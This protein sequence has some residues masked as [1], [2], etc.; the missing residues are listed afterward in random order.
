MENSSVETVTNVPMPKNI[1]FEVTTLSKTLAGALF[2]V[3]PFVGAY[4]GAQYRSVLPADAITTPQ[5][6][7]ATTLKDTMFDALTKTATGPLDL[8]LEQTGVVSGQSSEGYNFPVKEV[9]TEPFP[10]A[11]TDTMFFTKD[12]TNAYYAACTGNQCVYKKVTNVDVKTIDVFISTAH[13]SRAV[14]SRYLK[15][16]NHI[17]FIPPGDH[18]TLNALYYIVPTTA[19]P[20]TLSYNFEVLL[21][22]EGSPTDYA[23]DETFI[24]KSGQ[25]DYENTNGHY[26]KDFTD[27][28]DFYAHIDL[29]GP[30]QIHLGKNASW[31]GTIF[32]DKDINNV[33][34]RADLFTFNYGLQG[35]GPT[36]QYYSGYTGQGPNVELMHQNPVK[37]GGTF[38][39]SWTPTATSTPGSYYSINCVGWDEG[40]SHAG[41][42]T[43]LKIRVI[44]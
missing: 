1:L 19:G 4:I 35:P 2:I 14:Q 33:T 38:T 13:G 17:Y 44:D 30:S 37:S 8:A 9:T 21:D 32:D 24:Y 6:T 31:T 42:T 27:A 28:V 34:C 15:D 7:T 29:V 3:L 26:T 41:Y 25:I 39:I 20:E 43:D 16:K 23:R 40:G 12:K 11:S 36:E 5:A 10:N 22:K 18:S